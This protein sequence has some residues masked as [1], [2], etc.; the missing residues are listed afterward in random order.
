[1]PYNKEHFSECKCNIEQVGLNERSQCVPIIMK[2][3]QG[4]KRVRMDE[5]A[6]RKKI[7]RTRQ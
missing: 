5:R 4:R 7:K 6:E 3:K 2:K 1:V